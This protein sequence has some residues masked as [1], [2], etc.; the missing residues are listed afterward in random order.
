MD[1]L[2]ILGFCGLLGLGGLSAAGWLAA[3][4]QATASVDNL[5]L[6]LTGL[7]FAVLGFGYDAWLIRS[8]AH[9]Q[10]EKPVR[11]K[12]ADKKPKTRSVPASGRGYAGAT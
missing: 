1:V 4:G 6:T 8:L 9:R 5:F 2:F 11:A 12:A 7:L 3:T 10:E